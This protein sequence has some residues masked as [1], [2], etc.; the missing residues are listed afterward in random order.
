LLKEY[1]SAGVKG[2]EGILSHQVSLSLERYPKY[3]GAHSSLLLV[4]TKQPRGQEGT[5]FYPYRFPTK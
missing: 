2:V 5:R 1:E 4:R 3:A